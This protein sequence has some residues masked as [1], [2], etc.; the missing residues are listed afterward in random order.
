MEFADAAILDPHAATFDDEL[1]ALRLRVD[2]VSRE[3]DQLLA[4]V[5]I[6]QEISSSLHFSE[7]L[8]RIA[9]RL[10]DMFGLDRCSI[11]L[12]GTGREEV[13][14]VATY[15]D[16]SLRN[17][18][19]DLDRYPELR[20]AFDSG[21]TV[22]IPEASLDPLLEGAR[23]ALDERSVRSIVVLPIRWRTSVIGAI[24][25]RTERGSV[26]FTDRDIR[27]SEVIASLTA[28]ALRNA[29][30]FEALQRSSGEASAR[31]RQADLERIALVAFVRRLLQRFA[32][33]EEHAWAETLLPRASDEELDRLT[34]VAMQVIAEE[35]KG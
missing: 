4:V 1:A 27:F 21:Q 20:R 14:L 8:Q 12:V 35:A 17:L 10:G 19:V 32:T 13:R 24:F 6:L 28:K 18:V 25:L 5:D 15:E 9:R 22:F 33:S 34:S 26:P 31:A 23:L 2:D 16:P 11:Y 29:H 7:I 3:R 30:R